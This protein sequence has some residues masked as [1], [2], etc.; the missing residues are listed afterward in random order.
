VCGTHGHG[1]DGP[2]KGKRNNRA[3]RNR[4]PFNGRASDT[5]NRGARFLTAADSCPL[6][7][8]LGSGGL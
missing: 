6:V 2:G 3:G 8:T 4:P 1:M 5:A 7:A